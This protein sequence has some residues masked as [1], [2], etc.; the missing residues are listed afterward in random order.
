M[1][2]RM[3]KKQ[4][5]KRISRTYCHDVITA[6]VFIQIPNGKITHTFKITK[7]VLMPNMFQVFD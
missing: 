3:T 7:N 1:S 6:S 4:R 2:V 5:T